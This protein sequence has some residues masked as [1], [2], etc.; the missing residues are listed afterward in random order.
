MP[1]CLRHV[2]LEQTT[3]LMASFGYTKGSSEKYENTKMCLLPPF[4]SLSSMK[5]LAAAR[6]Q[7]GVGKD[8]RLANHRTSKKLECDR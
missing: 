3:C 5:R 8:E 4:L 2:F 7:T 6:L 1:A